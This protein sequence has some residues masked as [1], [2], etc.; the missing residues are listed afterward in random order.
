MVIFE[1]LNELTL[2]IT[3]QGGGDYVFTKAGAFI[4]G[5]CRGQKNYTFT[6][7]MLGPEQN[8]GQAF[9]HQMMRRFTGENLPLMKVEFRGDSVTYYANNQ[10]HVV[11]YRLQ[12]GETISVESENILA[13]TRDCK[14]GVRFL[15]QGVISQKGLATSTLTGQ[16]PCAFVAVLVDGNPLVLSNAGNGST[17]EIDPDAVVCWVGSDPEFRTDISW[18][19]F[20][21]QASGESYMFEWTPNNPATVII[22]PEERT[23]GL[24]VSMDGSATGSRPTTQ[25]RR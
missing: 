3:C 23:S 17:L 25:R 10:Q 15:A 5:E 13:F 2:K 1:T 9:L 21:G 16:G 14:Y 20:I 18:R 7:V 6:K 11:V 4:A 22:Q 8:A 12:M 19:N 24:D